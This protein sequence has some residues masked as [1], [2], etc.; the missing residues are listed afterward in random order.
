MDGVSARCKA[1]TY[2][3]QHNTEKCRQTSMPLVGFE[4][5]IPVFERSRSTSQTAIAVI[6]MSTSE[7]RKSAEV[8]LQC[9]RRRPA[10]TV[11]LLT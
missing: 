10:D 4:P 7:T 6:S 5:M 1:S 3:E 9:A 2:T 8:F 11:Y